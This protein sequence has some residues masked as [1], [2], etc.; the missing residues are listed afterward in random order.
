MLV[1]C[2]LSYQPFIHCL[3]IVISASFSTMFV[4]C[5]ISQ[6]IHT[7]C[8]LSYQSGHTMFVHCHISQVIHT[9]CTLSYQSGHTMFVHCHISQVIYCLYII[10][11]VH[12]VCTDIFLLI[13]YS[14]LKPTMKTKQHI[15]ASRAILLHCY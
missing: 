11:A 7:V 9:V 3:Y 14:S 4:H 10:S 12:S 8:T 6:V 13:F 2:N 1:H 15:M 5:H